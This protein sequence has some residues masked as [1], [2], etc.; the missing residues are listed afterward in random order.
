MSTL[1]TN[2]GTPELENARHGPAP[3]SVDSLPAIHELSA[4]GVGIGIKD[5]GL[6]APRPI[7]AKKSSTGERLAD[8]GARQVH[9]RSRMQ[10][11]RRVAYSWHSEQYAATRGLRRHAVVERTVT[12]YPESST[13]S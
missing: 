11:V 1:R 3:A 8:V 6:V 13:T 10:R 12:P 4:L 9:P 5:G 7:P 2:P